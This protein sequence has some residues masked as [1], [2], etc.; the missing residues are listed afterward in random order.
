MA[1]YCD[2]IKITN[3]GTEGS[4]LKEIGKA[5]VQY[6]GSAEGSFK[7]K[8]GDNIKKF[9]FRDGTLTSTGSFSDY[10]KGYG[11]NGS[12]IINVTTVEIDNQ[13]LRDKKA[14]ENLTIEDIINALGIN[15][16]EGYSFIE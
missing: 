8:I 15:T 14:N 13:T 9:A 3:F 7:Y 1:Q 2:Q 10:G 16:S 12:G 11:N 4:K 6:C 5:I